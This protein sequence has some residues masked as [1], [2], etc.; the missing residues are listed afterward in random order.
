MSA[1]DWTASAGDRDG[2]GS[3]EQR[4]SAAELALRAA[5]MALGQW[6]G[7]GDYAGLPW[8]T[9]R[10]AAGRA[11][12]QLDT[13]VRRLA[14]A[15]AALVGDIQAATDERLAADQTRCSA[16]WGVCPEHGNTLSSSGGRSW[17]RRPGC[18]RSWSGSRVSG[19]CDEPAAV[20][21]A[22]RTGAQLR[23]CAGHWLD[24][25]ELL[26]GAQVVRVLPAVGDGAR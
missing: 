13:A 1:A 26:V 6:Q 25:R 19:H 10:A 16:Q 9:R 4:V 20:I 2:V 21:V 15:R 12:A 8:S 18:G 11:L 22:D 7:N 3:G 14:G 17:C 24:A 23:L 5:G